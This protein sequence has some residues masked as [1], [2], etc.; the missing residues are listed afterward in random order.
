M[1]PAPLS[2]IPEGLMSDHGKMPLEW[3]YHQVSGLCVCEEVWMD[4]MFAREHPSGDTH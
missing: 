2:S 1:L 3:L 4:M